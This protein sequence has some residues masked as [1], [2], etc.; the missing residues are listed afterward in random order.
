LPAEA[1]DSR[2]GG[3]KLSQ[4][5]LGLDHSQRKRLAV[6]LL[7]FY[8]LFASTELRGSARIAVREC[9]LPLTPYALQLSAVVRLTSFTT[10]PTTSVRCLNTCLITRQAAPAA[11]GLARFTRGPALALTRMCATPTTFA[12]SAR[13]G[14][15]AVADARRPPGV[16]V[17]T[18]RGAHV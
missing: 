7:A 4:L 12:T 17:S 16:Y 14:T 13:P 18:G 8:P 10:S 9:L 3:R 1:P 2:G 5:E 11:L 15:L 6:R